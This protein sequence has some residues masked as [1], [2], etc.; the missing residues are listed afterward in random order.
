MPLCRVLDCPRG[1]LRK[2]VAIRPSMPS[3]DVQ[4]LKAAKRLF[5]DA[6]QVVRVP[7]YSYHI[8]QLN[9]R[10]QY[11]TAI[12]RHSFISITFILRT[13][14]CNLNRKECEETVSIRYYI[15]WMELFLET[16]GVIFQ[17]RNIRAKWPGDQLHHLFSQCRNITKH[18]REPAHALHLGP[19]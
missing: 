16:V 7:Y 1:L 5:W 10:T 3:W 9:A 4:W 18:Y 12:H 2:H 15:Y 6:F 14:D 8:S 11:C 17:W 19:S 13:Y